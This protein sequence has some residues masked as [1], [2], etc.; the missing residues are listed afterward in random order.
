[1]YFDKKIHSIG[2]ANYIEGDSAI[3]G[4]DDSLKV[5]RLIKKNLYS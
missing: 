5:S 2:Y 4:Y 1:M 3:V